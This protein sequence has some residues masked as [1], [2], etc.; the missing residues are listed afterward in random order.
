MKKLISIVI[1][2]FNEEEVIEELVRRLSS[3]ASTC[4]K[5]EFEFIVVDNGSIDNTFSKLLN[6]RKKDKRVKILK[7]VK[8]ATCDGGIIAGLSYAIGDAAIVMMADLQD[9]PDLIPK[10]LKKWE[11]GYSI[12][13]GIVKKRKNIKFTRRLATYLFYKLMTILTQGFLPE[14][15]SDFR[16]MDRKAYSIITRLPEHNKFFRGLVMWTGFKE[17][18]IEFDRP[19]RFA[20]RSKAY[21]LTVLS[22]AVNGI[23]SFTNLPLR[24][25]WIFVL[26]FSFYVLFSLFQG[27]SQYSLILVILLF[28]ALMIAMQGEYTLRIFEEVRN[29]PNFIVQETY[30]LQSE[31]NKIIAKKLK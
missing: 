12:V 15:V 24:I 4:K 25:F 1:P 3:V 8:N 23:I 6:A 26:F 17:I 14:N 27:I 9:D 7:L 18:G 16:L 29:R 10:F 2:A 13:Y 22:V 21:F 19:K 30:G 5:Y 20:G 28:L 11:E 31:K